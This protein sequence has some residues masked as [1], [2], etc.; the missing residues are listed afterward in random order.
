MDERFAKNKEEKVVSNKASLDKNTIK[1]NYAFLALMI[2]GMVLGAIVGMLFP[3]FGHAIKPLGTVFINMMFC[4]VVPLVFASIAG[5]IANMSSR[6]R[7]GKIMGA[8]IG[9]FVVTGIIAAI[10]MLRRSSSSR[11]F[12]S[13]GK[14][15]LQKRWA[16]MRPSPI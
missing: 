13:P 3:S 6:G 4:V 12:W 10:I 14:T 16:S 15:W 5:S 8:S 7:A 1:K 2:G 9:I 11:R